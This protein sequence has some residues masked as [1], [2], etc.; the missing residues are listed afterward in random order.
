M[1]SAT[2]VHTTSIIDEQVLGGRLEVGLVVGK[3]LSV[4]HM[5]RNHVL[6][7]SVAQERH[8]LPCFSFCNLL[9][10]WE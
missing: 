6:P 5:R 2:R 9:S 3:K 1:A 10:G 4:F 7:L 8:S